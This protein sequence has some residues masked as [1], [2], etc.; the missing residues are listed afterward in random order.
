[1]I[2]KILDLRKG[3][4]IVKHVIEY[5]KQTAGND[6]GKDNIIVNFLSKQNQMTQ[7]TFLTGL[8]LLFATYC[9]QL[10]YPAQNVYLPLCQSEEL[11]SLR[12]QILHQQS[13]HL[14]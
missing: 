6:W 13:V 10:L 5:N 7:I 2:K 1:M 14:R 4:D 9:F 3:Q 8:A 11:H 12:Y